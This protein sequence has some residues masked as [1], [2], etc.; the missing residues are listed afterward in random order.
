MAITLTYTFVGGTRA[1][2]SQVNSNFSTLSTRA[3]DKT[4]DTMT[5]HLLFTDATYDIGATGA[6][7]PRDFYLSRNATIGGTL[8]VTGAATLSST[9]AVTGTSTIAALSATSGT[10]STTL[11]VTGNATL[12]SATGGA[13]IIG[14]GV[15]AST[16]RFLEPSG[17]GTNYSEFKAQAQAG[18]ITYTLPAADA[19]GV[20]T[21]SGAGALSWATAA[22][23]KVV[24]IVTASYSTQ[25]TSSSSAYADTGLTCTITPTSASNKVLVVVSQSGI[26]KTNDTSMN[27][28]LLRAGSDIL[29]FGKQAGY[30]GSA[31]SNNAGSSAA[32][33]LDSP[34]TTSA[35]IY[36]TQFASDANIATVQIQVNSSI[37]TI[38][39]L[40]VTP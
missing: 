20:L 22:S 15:A 8:D 34:A 40:E 36:K 38:A 19:A 2:A 13:A 21:S 25:T 31:A 3:L 17:S 33:Y 10:F 18:N 1:L 4:G 23:S 29:V 28:K 11:A 16:L 5:G 14:G 12:A 7:R 35:T 6:T 30:T 37:S 24:Q 32:V 39:L 9:L 27:I 26:F